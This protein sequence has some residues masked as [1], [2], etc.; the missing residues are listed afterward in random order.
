MLI[1][2]NSDWISFNNHVNKAVTNKY[3]TRKL[4]MFI[5]KIQNYTIIKNKKMLISYNSDWI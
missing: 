3:F 5:I 2:Y 1:S 4:A